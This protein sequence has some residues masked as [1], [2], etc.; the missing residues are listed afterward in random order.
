MRT[1][2]KLR[3]KAE[4]IASTR[5]DAARQRE[6]RERARREREEQALRERYLTGL[7]KRERHA[8]ERVDGLIGTKHPGDYGAAVT[9]LVDLRDIAGRNRRN[10]VFAQRLATIRAGHAEKPALLARIAKAGL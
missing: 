9:L 4:A 8:W 2:G 10:A 7:A 3:V 5:L 6:T 1:A